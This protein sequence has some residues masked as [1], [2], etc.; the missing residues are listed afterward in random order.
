MASAGLKTYLNQLGQLIAIPRPTGPQE[1]N[2]SRSFGSCYLH[3]ETPPLP[4]KINP[5]E[6]RVFK[7]LCV[8]PPHLLIG[9]LVGF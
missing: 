5:S 6:W 4:Q 1:P 9:W 7:P 8:M 3:C 2:P